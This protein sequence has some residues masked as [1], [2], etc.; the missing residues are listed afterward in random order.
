MDYSDKTQSQFNMGIGT[1]IR[2]DNSL[3]DCNAFSQTS[4]VTGWYKATRVV[5]Q[6]VSPF[7]TEKELDEA[8]DKRIAVEE[9][10]QDHNLYINTMKKAHKIVGKGLP[11]SA[12]D[13]MYDY[14]RYLRKML[15]KYKLYMKMVD[16][17][18]AAARGGL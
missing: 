10:I 14:E 5:E 2:I 16:T 9:A 13:L 1:V 8:K 15:M 7:L 4:N 18:L 6:E 12:F 3:Q 17:R 11:R